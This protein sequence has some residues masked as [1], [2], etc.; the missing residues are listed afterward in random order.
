MANTN[1]T[2]SSTQSK[3]EKIAQWLFNNT[4]QCRNLFA[5]L[6]ITA[7]TVISIKFNI[8]LGRLSAV[9]E[10][11][12]Q[13]LPTGYALLDLS[14]LFLSGYVG[15]K[16]RS[17]SRKVVAWGWFMFLLCLSLWAAA[18]FT[19][20]IDARANNRD[21]EHAI[22][23]Q[24]LEVT[25][26]N[27]EALIW[28]T[29]VAEAINF[30]SKHQAT[31]EGVQLKQ[32]NAADTLHSLESELPN[33][34]MAIYNLI[35]PRYS[36]EP[37]TLNTVVRLLWAGALTLSP[38]VI[39][40]LMGADV[41]SKSDSMKR[42]TIPTGRGIG[43]F[44]SGLKSKIKAA[45]DKRKLRRLLVQIESNQHHE[46]M[47]TILTTSGSK[48]NIPEALDSLKGNNQHTEALDLRA[49]ELASK[50]LIKQERG[51]VNRAAIGKAC[52]LYNRDGISK[53][54]S[55]LIDSGLLE[56][57]SNGQL[58]KPERPILRVV[59]R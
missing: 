51:R 59:Q 41:L 3:P 49:F 48:A 23:Q 7:L 58:S 15:L 26:L 21:L 1:V 27:N 54:I 44:Y 45:K 53:V 36:L 29:N 38:I 52:G 55:A 28:Q 34:T 42:S 18:S 10:T 22:E 50:W 25:N 24:R 33:P 4:G 19:L 39:M 2:L 5:F 31:L 9:D 32:R 8:E 46:T 20:S 30:K 13:L 17:I 43:G 11:S 57:L 12:R 14:A 16:T 56:R 37:E 47:P 35:A 40:L 6:L